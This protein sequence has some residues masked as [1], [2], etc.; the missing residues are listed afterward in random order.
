MARKLIFDLDR[1]LWRAT[2]EYHPKM[3]IPP[4][5][6]ETHNVL[7]YL[8]QRGHSMYIASRSK[9][10]IKCNQFIDKYFSDIPFKKRAIYYTPFSKSEHMVDLGAN[11]GNFIMFDDE[12]HILQLL[13]C[14]YPKCTTILCYEYLKWENISNMNIACKLFNQF[15]HQL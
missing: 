8:S 10:P 1:T 2:V 7:R 6:I 5:N 15:I 13:K 11:D 3:R 4:I 9:E 12:K 14:A